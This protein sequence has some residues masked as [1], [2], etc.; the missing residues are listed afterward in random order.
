VTPTPIL[1]LSCVDFAYSPERPPALRNVSLDVPP[2]ARVAILGPNGGGKTTLLHVLLGILA[3]ASGTLLVDGKPP[4]AYARRD[5]SRIVGLVPQREHVPF[6]FALLDYVLL[7]RAPYLGP[8]EMPGAA[9]LDAARRAIDAVGLLAHAHHPVT[10]LSGGERQLAMIARSLAQAPRV[11]LLDE[12]TSHLDLANRRAVQNVLLAQAQRGIA[13]VFTTHDPSLA[14]GIADQAVLVRDGAILA[15]GP[16][17]SIFTP[18][19]LS[20]AYGIPIQVAACGSR[21][22]VLP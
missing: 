4:G 3:P 9:D 8:L 15:A 2:G 7:G 12:P 18:E 1:S 5:I 14:D 22:I 6:D 21:R 17:E 13:I 19:R 11:L 10:A 16:L 20:A